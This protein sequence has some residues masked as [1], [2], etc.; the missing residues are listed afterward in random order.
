[1]MSDLCG[2]DPGTLEQKGQGEE[3]LWGWCINSKSTLCLLH[4]FPSEN[5]KPTMIKHIPNQETGERMFLQYSASV[6]LILTGQFYNSQMQKFQTFVQQRCKFASTEMNNPKDY[7][8]Q[9]HKNARNL[10]LTSLT[11]LP[12][13]P[14][15]SNALQT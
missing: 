3:C 9:C 15:F 6:D 4:S 8:G 10:I 1:M 11:T 13:T 7:S 2:Q 14:S 5:L 12:Y